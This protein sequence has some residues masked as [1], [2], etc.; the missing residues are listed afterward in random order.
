MQLLKR[1]YKTY[2]F[3]LNNLQ[4]CQK[5][6]PLQ[7]VF[8]SIRFKVNKGWSTAVLLFFALNFPFLSYTASEKAS[9]TIKHCGM[10]RKCVYL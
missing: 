8:H 5:S 1:C 2:L 9:S 6:V 3:P 7:C 10:R 4:K